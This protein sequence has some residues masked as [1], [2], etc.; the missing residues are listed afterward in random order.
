M[1]VNLAHRLKLVC[2]CLAVL[3]P[4]YLG[5]CLLAA[6]LL[7]RPHKFA[8]AKREH[9]EFEAKYGKKAS[10]QPIKTFFEYKYLLSIDGT[11]AAYRLPALLAGTSTVFKQVCSLCVC[12]C[13]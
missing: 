12:L 10:L 4:R 6:I 7:M 1:Y 11:V 13:A 5:A 2:A 3:L 9:R 8:Q